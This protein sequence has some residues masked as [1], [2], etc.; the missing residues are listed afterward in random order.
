MAAT[1]LFGKLIED[2]VSQIQA[3]D[4]TGL[5]DP[6]V[7][8]LH[9]PMDDK[10]KLVPQLPAIIVCPFGNEVILDGTNASDRIQ[11]PILVGILEAQS[12]IE[13]DSDPFSKADTYLF[14]R[15]QIIDDQIHNRSFTNATA[16]L[17]DK[18]IEP[19]PVINIQA[20]LT[21]DMFI[22]SFLVRAECFVTRRT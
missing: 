5:P 19:N 10:Y 9:I 1:S 2:V 3:L 8:S 11:Y 18:K 12:A 20:Y 13:D 6:N 14:W 15:E 16:E 17:T 21:Q 22:S 7:V 4:L